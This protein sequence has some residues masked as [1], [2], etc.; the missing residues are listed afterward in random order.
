MKDLD[1]YLLAGLLLL[2]IIGGGI[3]MGK[4]MDDESDKKGFIVS[5][6]DGWIIVL[7]NLLI[8]S[9]LG[10]ALVIPIYGAVMLI[11]TIIKALFGE[12]I[13]NDYTYSGIM[14]GV[15]FSIYSFWWWFRSRVLG[16]SDV[17]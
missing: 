17:F 4:S 2:I 15:L 1:S 10:F 14:F 7:P 16:K 13:L 9:S 5:F 11:Y 3:F 12:F 8:V 6:L